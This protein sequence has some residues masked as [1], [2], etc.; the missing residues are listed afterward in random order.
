MTELTDAQYQMLLVFRSVLRRYQM[1][2]AAEAAAVGL[3]P[4][5]HLLLLA[6][7]AHPGPG[8]PSIVDLADYLSI[9]H[10]SAVALVDRVQKAQ[11]VTRA[12]D[13]RDHRK[14]R[15]SLTQRG[16]QT[17]SRLAEMHVEELE[18]ISEVLQVSRTFQGRFAEE[19]QRNF[20]ERGD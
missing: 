14:V 16:E 5:Q 17:I 3:T 2:S 1:W 15:V 4:Q 18:R 10:H 7:R 6:V 11:F 19:F 8:G 9:R 12:G 20:A 13:L